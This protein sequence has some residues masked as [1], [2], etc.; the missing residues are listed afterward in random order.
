MPLFTLVPCLIFLYLPVHALSGYTPLL[1]LSARLSP[2]DAYLGT[3][4]FW[5]TNLLYLPLLFF[6][7]LLPFTAHSNLSQIPLY[8][9]LGVL[10]LLVYPIELW[11]YLISNTLVSSPA[12]HTYGLNTLL[13]N[14]LNRYHPL[15]FY[16]SV[17]LLLAALVSTRWGSASRTPFSQSRTILAALS[18]TWYSIL[19]NLVA[20]WMG[21]W[22]A[23][24]EGTWGGWWNWDSSETF[25]L[26]VSLIGLSSTHSLLTVSTFQ[27]YLT[28]LTAMVLLF[29]VSYFFIQLNFELVSHNFGSKFFFFFNNNLFFLE[30]VFGLTTLALYIVRDWARRTAFTQVMGSPPKHTRGVSG[31]GPVLPLLLTAYIFYW[32][33]WSYK[34]LVSYFAWNFAHLNVFNFETSLQSTNLILCLAGIIWLVRWDSALALAYASLLI[35]SSHFLVTAF[36]LIRIRTYFSVLHHSILSI[37][38]LNILLFDLVLY[39]W[40]LVSPFDTVVTSQWAASVLFELSTL[41]NLAIELVELWGTLESH[42]SISWNLATLTNTP[43]LN[44]FS[45]LSATEAFYNMYAL[46]AVYSTVQL[47]LEL[48]FIGVINILFLLVPLFAPQ[49]I[50]GTRRRPTI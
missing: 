15:V 42:A 32:V 13:T 47:F 24:Q 28:K 12:Y 45:L 35:T 21:S 18:L 7:L 49:L 11:D 38:L 8:V 22:W 36:A 17:F 27:N 46:A 37:L 14:V 34:P 16:L 26:L 25:G 43:S 41:D 48:P 10:A 20:L 3:Y 5:W 31:Y 23:L 2:N 19:V 30:A 9:W 4:Y 29:I 39:K 44:F 1:D 50:W 40:T 6:V 33:L